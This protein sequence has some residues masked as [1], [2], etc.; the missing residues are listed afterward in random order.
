M[1]GQPIESDLK[2]LPSSATTLLVIGIHREEL[3]FGEAVAAGL[4]RGRFDV[5]KIPEGLSG[6]HPRA[7]QRFHFD[8][9]HRELYLQLLPHIQPRH[10]RVIDLHTGLDPQGPC[11]DIYSR[12]TARLAENLAQVDDIQPAP[13]LISLT[14]SDTTPS[15]ETVIPPE[16]WRNPR[17]LYVGVEIYLPE[18]GAGRQ[19]DRKYACALLN[20]LSVEPIQP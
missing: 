9:L 1:S 20:A 19:I 15:A 17:F 6:R 14:P 12:D 10:T 16:V 18:A 13:R 7:D 2:V 5:L 4:D 11:A 3:A 8:T